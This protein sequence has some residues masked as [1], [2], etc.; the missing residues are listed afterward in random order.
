[1]VIKQLQKRKEK[2][3]WI[4]LT[5]LRTLIIFKSLL[6]GGK[7]INQLVEILENQPYV[8]KSVSKDTVRIAINT[9]KTAGC[10]IV[11]PSK[12]NKYL[13]ELISHPFN[14]NVN[15][16]ELNALIDL[17]DKLSQNYN[18]QEVLIMNDLFDKIFALTCNSNQI[19]MVSESKPLGGINLNVLSTLAKPEILGKKISIKYS[20][21]KY[22]IED[23]DIIPKKLSYDNAKLHLFCYSFK[24]NKTSILNIERILEINKIDISENYETENTYSVV[25]KLTGN[26]FEIFTKADYEEIIEKTQNFVKVSANVENEFLF[27]QRILTYGSDVKIISPD[28]F[29]EKLID[30]IKLIRKRYEEV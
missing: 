22:G 4:S 28:F 24:Y 13:Y 18:W 1:M 15:N 3:I 19:N 21:P 2:K 6:N 29:K 27:I 26:S 9:L 14:L 8:N 5:G 7:T 12:A 17:R 16:E 23:I 10:E 30:K 25:Y 11:R 20:S